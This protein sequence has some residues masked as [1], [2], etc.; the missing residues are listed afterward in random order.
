VFYSNISIETPII[1]SAEWRLN[2]GR[3]YFI[4]KPMQ[5][6]EKCNKKDYSPKII[7]NM[8][9]IAFFQLTLNF[10][11]HFS[12]KCSMCFLTGAFFFLFLVFGKLTAN[13]QGGSGN[14]E[15]AVYLKI[16]DTSS[17]Q[18][19]FPPAGKNIVPLHPIYQTFTNFGVTNVYKPFSV[20]RDFGTCNNG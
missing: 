5:P 14:I 7:F 4:T 16:Q 11:K 15:G 20:C 8:K 9:Q 19:T 6:N 12:R 10:N 13:A 2:Y 17:F 3:F 18:I 1:F